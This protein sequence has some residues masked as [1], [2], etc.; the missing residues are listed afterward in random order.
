MAST[1]VEDNLVVIK[2]PPIGV[3]KTMVGIESTSISNF[4]IFNNIRHMDLMKK[5]LEHAPLAA[6]H[7]FSMANTIYSVPIFESC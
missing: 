1:S 3:L 5:Q 2:V 4:N 6:K 7:V